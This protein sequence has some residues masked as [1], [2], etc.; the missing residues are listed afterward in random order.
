VLFSIVG[1]HRDTNLLRF[2]SESISRPRAVTGNRPLK[3]YKIKYK[4]QKK[5]KL[6]PIH[7]LKTTKIATNSD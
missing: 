1:H 2:V 7:Q 3:N 6:G 5:K 4:A